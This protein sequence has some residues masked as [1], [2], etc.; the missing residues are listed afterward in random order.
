MASH[1]PS[2]ARPT[3]AGGSIDAR[4]SSGT[5]NTFIVQPGGT[6][7]DFEAGSRTSLFSARQAGAEG[8]SQELLLEV[9]PLPSDADALRPWMKTV[10][11]DEPSPEVS[12]H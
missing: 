1:E 11:G 3:E 8:P 9:E 6:P 5:D 10:T 7:E 4:E 12:W 2:Q